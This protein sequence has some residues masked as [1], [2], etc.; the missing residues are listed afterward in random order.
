MAQPSGQPRSRLDEPVIGAVVRGALRFRGLIGGL[1]LA[2]LVSG[3]LTLR[4]APVD[5]L[6]EFTPPYV[7]IQTESLGLSAAE[8]EQF[9]TVP[10]EAD[11]LNGVEGVDTI[12]STSTPGLSSIILIF[13]QGYDVYKG[14]QLVQERLTQLG[15]AAFPHVSKPPAMLPPTSSASR[16]MMVGLSSEKLTPIQ[17]SVIARWTVRPRLMGVPGVANVAVWGMRDQQI[18]VQVDPQKLKDRKVRLSQVISTAGNAQVAS[19]VSYLEASVPGTGGFIETPTQRLPIRNVFDN[20]A[21][22]GLLGQVPVEGTGGDLQLKDV[23]T[24]VEEHQPLIGD[25]VVDDG[26]GLLLVI[27]KFP[28]ADTKKIT[29]AVEAEFDRLAPGLAG[30]KTDTSVF[31]PATY[32]DKALDNLGLSLLIAGVLLILALG[33]LLRG[34][35]TPLVALVTIPVSMTAAAMVL[36]A[37]GQSFNAISLAGLT[38]GLVIVIDDAVATSYS[39]RH[40]LRRTADRGQEDVDLA[41]LSATREVRRP[42][43]YAAI[44]G[45]LAVVPIFAMEGRPGSFLSPL[46]LGYVLAV[47]AS[48]IV[49]LTLTPAL[50]S[51][52]P[53]HLDDAPPRRLSQWYGDKLPKAIGRP[54]ATLAVAGVAA[55]LVAITLPLLNVSV[56]PTLKDRDLIVRIES[57]AGTSNVAM[58]KIATDLSRDLR[59]LDGIDN[60]GATIGRAV[61]GDR[62]V[63]V[64]SG[65]VSVSINSDADYDDTLAAIEETASDVTGVDA[66]VVTRSDQ[67]V[68]DVGALDHGENVV[69]DSSFR[70]LTG[71][72]QPITVRVFGQNLQ[73]LTKQAQRVQKVVGQ[74]EGVVSPSLESPGEQPTLEIEVDIEKAREHGIKPGDVRRAEAIMLQGILVGSVFD[75]QKV[76]DVVV[77]GSPQLA[78]KEQALRDLLI[79][80]P[81]GGQVKLSEIADIRKTTAPTIIKRDSVSRK[82]DISL[83]VEG[84]SA[85]AVADDLEKMLEDLE[86]PQEYHAAVI[87]RTVQEEVNTGQSWVLVLAATVAI[88]L[89]MQALLQSWRLSALALIGIPAALGGG[90]IATL[91]LGDGLTIGAAS[92]LLALFALAARHTTTSLR[93]FQDLERVEGQPFSLGLV[94]RGAKERLSPVFISIVAIAV[95]MIPFAIF[96]PREGLEILAPMSIVIL[97]GLVTVA[98]SSLFF[99]PALYLQVRKGQGLLAEP[100][101]DGD[102]LPPAR[103]TAGTTTK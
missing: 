23:A 87:E 91:I 24:I 44:I 4:E 84:R 27:D 10:L 11:L 16:V 58:T 96:G 72:D 3:F 80:V 37:M 22:P 57:P 2:I 52:L 90:V 69:R 45:L 8:V 50:T 17:K 7:E 49:A 19:P 75:D 82:L 64:N 14:R 56:V 25:A 95:T 102:N 12:R 9:L 70:A 98:M 54:L 38:A 71:V 31:R 94:Q 34:W 65:E 55:A 18:Q 20:I 86:M 51:M 6:P 66:T 13:H 74:V 97:C 47:L 36:E 92:G 78:E 43:A 59:G 26:E 76:F 53:T 1:A 89:L 32:I 85:E 103:Q 5:A 62:I 63:D 79:D 42:L 29:A 93:H 33:A 48:M 99:L 30:M 28:G 46:A 81:A 100:P 73:T 15:G 41:V 60:V 21:S 39:I 68:R 88:L 67:R 35:H 61:T 77:Q 40:R 83:G 101:D